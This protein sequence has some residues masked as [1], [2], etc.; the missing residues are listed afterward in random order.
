MTTF[1]ER[2]RELR[3]TR[4][5]RISLRDLARRVEIDFTYLSK[6]EN[7]KVP[8]P[9]DEVIEKLARELE[10]DLEELLALAAKV[11][12]EDLRKAVAQD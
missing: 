2:I 5:N 4:D 11:S 12:Q 1:G 10:A 3:T 6:I 7:G 9:S 8:P